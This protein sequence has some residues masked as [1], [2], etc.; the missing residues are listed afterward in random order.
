MR[1]LYTRGPLLG[2]IIRR[3][4]AVAVDHCGVEI[5]GRVWDVAMWSPVQPRTRADW[6]GMRSRRLVYEIDVPLA[7]E[8]AAA[9][10]I[11]ARRGTGYDYLGVLGIPL[12][13]YTLDDPSRLICTSLPLLGIQAAEPAL[14]PPLRARNLDVGRS[15]GHVWSIAAARGGRC[16]VHPY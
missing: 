10:A 3:E 1:V 8:T 11:V 7:D 5:D 9:D 4:S 13:A 2:P 16:V 15:L 12:R 6:L 14:I